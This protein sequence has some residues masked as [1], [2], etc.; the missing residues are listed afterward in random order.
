MQALTFV[1]CITVCSTRRYGS[2]DKLEDLRIMYDSMTNIDDDVTRG[3]PMVVGSQYQ[4][5]EARNLVQ[6]CSEITV[7][8]RQCIYHSM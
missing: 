8:P 7:S 4:F 5:H 6:Q 2:V 3:V 1:F